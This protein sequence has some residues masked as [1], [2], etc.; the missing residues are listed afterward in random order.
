MV[1]GAASSGR[2][3]AGPPPSPDRRKGPFPMAPTLSVLRRSIVVFVAVL[4]AVSPVATGRAA[5]VADLQ[6][7]AVRE[8]ARPT[9]ELAVAGGLTSYRVDAELAPAEPAGMTNATITGRIEVEWINPA[10]EAAEVVHFR[11]YPNDPRYREG[12]MTITRA[13]IDGER[14]RPTLA[15]DDTLATF[16]LPE[17]IGPGETTSIALRFSATIPNDAIGSYGMFDH[18][19]AS[20]TY[21]LAHWFPLLAGYDPSTGFLTGPITVNGDPVFASAATFDVT[22]AAPSDFVIASTGVAVDRTETAGFATTRWVS[23]PAREFTLA[24]SPAFEMLERE[25]RGVN[26]RSFHLPGHEQRSNASLRWAHDAIAYYEDRIGAYPYTEFDIVDAPIGGGAAGIEF[27]GL[28]FIASSY[29]DER[30]DQERFPH[31]QEYTLVHEVLHQWWYNAVGNNHYDHA[32]IDEALTN[33]L[34]TLYFREIYGEETYDRQ[35][36]LNLLVPYLR[37]LHAF[38]EGRDGIVDMPADA[39]PS[40]TAYGILVYCKGALGF[41]TLMDEIGEEAYFEALRAYYD[42]FFLGVAGP[43][44]LRAAFET[45]SGRDLGDFWTHWFE[46]TNGM[47]DF[48]REVYDDAMA[49][50]G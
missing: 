4:L 37:F 27:P 39:F 34:T 21:T 33:Q 7:A 15:H 1:S 45:A 29:Y 16:E 17:P 50:L 3:V 26:V 38:P 23:G 25:E 30:L 8:L 48:P 20:D 44:D 41:L 2:A 11:L 46:E 31:G 28:V 10:G 9:V 35:I 43:D 19:V 40:S 22:L 49:A 47:E 12:D 32:F 13:H 18:D 42:A 24:A 6:W 36:L 14:V 5:D